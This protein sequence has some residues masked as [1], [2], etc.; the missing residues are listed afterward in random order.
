MRLTIVATAVLAL[1]G[2]TTPYKIPQA[3][4]PTANL[5]FELLTA[6]GAGGGT[7]NIGINT[8]CK[9]EESLTPFRLGH[10]FLSDTNKHS[11]KIQS[12]VTVALQADVANTVLYN[13]SSSLKFIPK[14]NANYLATFEYDS[15]GCR[16]SVF[17]V[18][19]SGNKKDVNITNC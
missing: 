15:S 19:S 5:D 8:G 18:D 3:S 10:H 9:T 14:T 16:L 11:T 7:L 4:V 12:N 2:C 17:E 13:C 1:A 6:S